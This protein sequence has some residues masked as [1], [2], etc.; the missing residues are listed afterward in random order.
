MSDV[1]LLKSCVSF[2]KNGLSEEKSNIPSLFTK[3]QERLPF[4]PALQR[5]IASVQGF[6]AVS[7]AFWGKSISKKS[8]LEK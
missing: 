4:V 3:A 6:M 7:G 8:S 5:R 2:T 1:T